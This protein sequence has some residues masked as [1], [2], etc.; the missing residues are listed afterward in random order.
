MGETYE[1]VN[2]HRQRYALCPECPCGK[3]NKDGKFSPVKGDSTKGYCHSCDVFFGLQREHAPSPPPI[4]EE[5]KDEFEDISR[6]SW[7][8]VSQSMRHTSPLNRWIESCWTENYH[9]VAQAYYLGADEEG[10]VVFWY[11]DHLGPRRK[12]VMA[13]GLDGKRDKAKPPFLPK[14]ENAGKPGIFGLHMLRFNKNPVVLVESEKTAILCAIACHE[15]DVP[16]CFMALGGK[17]TSSVFARQLRGR[18]VKVCLDKGED[19]AQDKL[20]GVLRMNGVNAVSASVEE[21]TSIIINDECPIVNKGEDIID[22]ALR[23]IHEHSEPC[24]AQ[25]KGPLLEVNS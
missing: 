9:E 12:K 23:K 4:R 11:V 6:P 24:Q 1:F 5:P 14:H 8:E 18:T 3:S 25:E 10:R 17:S 13:Y 2:G 20:I 21:I 7:K 19:E 15:F 16:Y 22:A